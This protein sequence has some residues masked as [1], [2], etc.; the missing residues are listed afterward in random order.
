MTLEPAQRAGSDDGDTH[1]HW[2]RMRG[3]ERQLHDGAALRISAL[4]LRLGLFRNRFPA[5][6]RDLHACID[7]LQEELHA[8]LQELRDVAAQLYPPLLDQAGLAAA[9]REL[10]CRLD[11]PLRVTA[12][13]ERFG[14]AAEGA[15]YFALVRRLTELPPD[16]RPVEVSVRREDDDLVVLVAP[17]NGARTLVG[18]FP[19][20]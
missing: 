16:R 3:L 8:V 13:D 19:C 14:P 15:A 12:P 10:A 1:G 4:A 2:L 18:R 5:E 6:D 17:G 7:G 11:V 20:A 9:L